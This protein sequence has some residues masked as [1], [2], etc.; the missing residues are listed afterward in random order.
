MPHSVCGAWRRGGGIKARD[1]SKRL[2]RAQSQESPVD[3]CT[4]ELDD[5]LC[6]LLV[7]WEP[8]EDADCPGDQPIGL[9]ELL[10]EQKRYTI[11][12]NCAQDG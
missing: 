6:L 4:G 2:T 8:S 10:P 5:G 12:L 1:V 11:V 7:G 9:C 3:H